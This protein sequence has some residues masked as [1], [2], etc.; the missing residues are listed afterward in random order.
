MAVFEQFKIE[1]TT[2]LNLKININRIKDEDVY[3]MMLPDMMKI[4]GIGK[5]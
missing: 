1:N 3:F 2:G 4:K 5:N